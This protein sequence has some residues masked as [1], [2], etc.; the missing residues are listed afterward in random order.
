MKALPFSRMKTVLKIAVVA[1]LFY[2]L[3]TKGLLSLSATKNAFARPERILSA[4]AIVLAS[5]LLAM[6]RWQ[7]LLRA[8][9]L[10]LRWSRIFELTFIGNFFNI[11]LPG[12]V[13][14]DVV[15]AF[16]VSKESRAETGRVFSTILFDRVAG[17]SGLVFIS[18]SALAF[19]TSVIQD[20]P[21]FTGIKVTLIA[22]AV[23]I[24]CFYGFLFL[25]KES[26][27]PVLLGLR[28]IELRFPKFGAFTRVYL[29]LRH[30][31]GHGSAVAG[32][33]LLSAFMHILVSTGGILFA[34]AL[35]EGSIPA[36]SVFVVVPLGFLVTAIPIMPAGVGTGHAAFSALF[37]LIGSE[38]GADI[39]NLYILV[40][41]ISSGIGGLV[42]LR[43]RAREPESLKQVMASPTD[44]RVI[45]TEKRSHDV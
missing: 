38:R 39:F 42:Y 41:L 33:L 9:G 1:L 30:Y 24:F 23:G 6:V 25:V 19:S 45:D 32:A 15:K 17:L 11:A 12:S 37:K 5:N 40:Q 8:Q 27:D 31:Q 14:G 21:L 16:Y 26:N 28:K 3:A 7:W 44:A 22:G 4:L 29:G 43:F 18:A 13:S 10:G 35:G 34:R 20:S 2:F 36:S